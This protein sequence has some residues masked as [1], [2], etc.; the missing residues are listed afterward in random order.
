MISPAVTLPGVTVSKGGGVA[1]DVW[2][3]E[4]AIV[5]IPVNTAEARK[6]RLRVIAD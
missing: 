1:A 6:R 5:P 2:K 3:E 4:G